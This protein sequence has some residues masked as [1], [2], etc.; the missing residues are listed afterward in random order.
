MDKDAERVSSDQF[1]NDIMQGFEEASQYARGQA[2]LRVTQVEIVE[3]SPTATMVRAGSVKIKNTASSASA[4]SQN[5]KPAP[6]RGM[7]SAAK[8]EAKKKVRRQLLSTK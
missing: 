7:I 4:V 1:F 3:A 2:N 6:R 8:T 5:N